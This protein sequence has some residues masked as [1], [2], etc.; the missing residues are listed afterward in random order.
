MLSQ[1]KLQSGQRGLSLPPAA[2][3]DAAKAKKKKEQKTFY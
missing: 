1:T 2:T 3:C